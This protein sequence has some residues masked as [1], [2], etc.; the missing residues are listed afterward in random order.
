[1]IRKLNKA[2]RNNTPN[3]L[4][5]VLAESDKNVEKVTTHKSNRWKEILAT[6]AAIAVLIGV[7]AG[8]AEIIGSGFRFN[9]ANDGTT[10]SEMI[11]ATNP[12]LTP[13]EPDNDLMLP[14]INVTWQQARDL[15][16]E[17]IGCSIDTIFSLNFNTH[18]EM[19]G[20]EP[21]IIYGVSVQTESE[22]YRYNVNAKTGQLIQYA[23][24]QE[25]NYLYKLCTQANA[26]TM[27]QA[28]SIVENVSGIPWKAWEQYSFQH[29]FHTENDHHY[30]LT[31]CDETGKHKYTLNTTN[32][33]IVDHK[34]MNWLSKVK[35]YTVDDIIAILLDNYGLTRDMIQN[36]VVEL[37]DTGAEPI[38][39]VTY[40]AGEYEFEDTFR[41]YPFSVVDHIIHRIDKY[42]RPCENDSF[43]LTQEEEEELRNAIAGYLGYPSGIYFG[44]IAY[45]GEYNGAH[46]VILGELG[47]EVVTYDNVEGLQFCYPTDDKLLLFHE[48]KGYSLKEAYDKGIVDFDD[49]YDLYVYHTPK[50]LQSMEDQILSDYQARNPGEKADALN[51]HFFMETDDIQLVLIYAD[52]PIEVAE[53]SEEIGSLTFH[54][55]NSLRPLAYQDGKFYSIRDAYSAGLIDQAALEMLHNLYSLSTCNLY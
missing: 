9:A 16:F 13:T 25:S 37:D 26:L 30:T 48:S 43:Y 7:G 4:P 28:I 53:G 15:V 6:A 5:A 33:T 42:D 14:V 55:K 17:E 51:I 3:V 45:Y 32:G 34:R 11:Q 29:D 49:L 1:M 41:F 38:Y 47:S 12:T 20:N 10:P 19:Q 39:R 52:D 24:S 44:K 18:T 2:F 21:V 22:A 36:L 27:T 23:H 46:A 35:P 50:L 31:F 40:T 8:A 54:F